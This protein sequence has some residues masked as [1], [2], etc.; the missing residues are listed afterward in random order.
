MNIP[1]QGRGSTQRIAHRFEREAREAFDD[2]WSSPTDTDPDEEAPNRTEWRWEDVRSALS[3]NDSPDIGF[4]RSLNPY[5][6]C[7]HGCAYCY[8]RPSHA[9][10]GL[11]PGLDFENR[12]VAKR[13]LA[14]RLRHELGRT[15]YQPA[16]VA[17]G[18]VTDAYQPLERQLGITRELLTVLWETRHPVVIIT[19]GSGV[20]RDLDLLAQLAQEGLAA[21]YVTVTTLD[22][23]LCRRLEPRAAA[24]ARRLQ[25]IE[26]L[27]QAGVPVGVSVAPQIPFLNDDMEQVLTAAAKVGA[28]RAFYTV[29]RLPWEVAPLMRNWLQTHY[30]ERAERVMARVQDLH[31]GRDYD[32]RMGNRMWGQ[33]IWADLLRQRFQK[34]CREL[35][36][37]GRE[38]V[39]LACDRFRPPTAAG[40]QLALW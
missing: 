12:L 13:G 20:L 7:E 6:G 27:T 22:P 32:P 33:G 18:S 34:A 38:H 21:V 26:A 10:L 5:R 3:Y 30:P 24:P 11:S 2:G 23:V 39:P 17:L 36:L 9:Y 25:M 35:G 28:K 4:D 14:D 1:G 29:L 16:P 37:A 8:A 40:P 19:K 31:G 15:G